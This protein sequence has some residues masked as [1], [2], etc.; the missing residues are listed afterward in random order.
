[1]GTDERVNHC[2]IQTSKCPTPI[3]RLRKLLCA[4]LLLTGY[5]MDCAGNGDGLAGPC[6]A[7][8]AEKESASAV[9]LKPKPS[10]EALKWGGGAASARKC[11]RERVVRCAVP[12]R[13]NEE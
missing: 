8:P 6:G 11:L 5:V 7:Q 3:R 9:S 13:S 4:T 1:M 2:V 12:S 10:I